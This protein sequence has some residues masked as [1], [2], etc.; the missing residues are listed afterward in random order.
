MAKVATVV[1]FDDK[2]LRDVVRQAAKEQLGDV[3]GGPGSAEVCIKAEQGDEK[4]ITATVTFK[5]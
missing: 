5:K 4:K 3:K 2:E 1:S